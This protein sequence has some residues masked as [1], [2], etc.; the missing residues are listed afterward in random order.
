MSYLKKLYKSGRLSRWLLFVSICFLILAY[1]S[2]RETTAEKFYYGCLEGQS[3]PTAEQCRCL[4][5]Y[6]FEHLESMQVIA[7][8]EPHRIRNDNELE[9]IQKVLQE[10]TGKCGW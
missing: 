8:M 4:T 2:F 10:G 9:N 6:V 3:N 1:F 7:I 5:D